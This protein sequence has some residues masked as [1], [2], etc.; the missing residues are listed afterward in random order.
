MKSLIIVLALT[1][2]AVTAQAAPTSVET[3]AYAQSDIET[4][5][6]ERGRVCWFRCWGRK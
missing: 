3:R 1:L 6:D 5:R 4:V 2:T